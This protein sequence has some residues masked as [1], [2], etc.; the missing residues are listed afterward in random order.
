LVFISVLVF[1]DTLEDF[2]SIYINGIM[3]IGVGL[4]GVI[5]SAIYFKHFLIFLVEIF[6]SIAN[7]AGRLFHKKELYDIDWAQRNVQIVHEC[8]LDVKKS[9]RLYLWSIFIC[10]ITHILNIATLAVIAWALKE[11]LALSK[12]TST[13]III[14]TLESVSPTP[15]GIGVVE[16]LTPKYMAS[17]GI[18]FSNALVIVSIFRFVYFYLPVLL[19]FYLSYR[20]YS[21]RTD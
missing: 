14:N 6:R 7:W 16:S 8:F 1:K 12:L 18:N 19:G 17:L 21:K 10:F 15:N 13:Y 3:A 4:M 2:P 5:I 20:S 11:S 9:P